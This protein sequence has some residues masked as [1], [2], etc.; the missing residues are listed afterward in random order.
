MAGLR[1]KER[2]IMEDHTIRLL[3]E[4][5]Q[6]CK[7]GIKSINQIREYVSDQGLK[8]IID[9]YQDEH[10]R[11]ESEAD[12][13]LVWH[14][15]DSR[16]PEKMAAA[17]AWFTTEMKMMM[18]DDD[19]QAAKLLTEGCNMG[20]QTICG[21]MNQYSGASKSSLALANDLVKTEEKFRD[22]MKLYL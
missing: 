19:K 2:K 1:Q 8:K 3:Q 4:C 9:K 7:M 5:S 13:L 20:I 11:L 22:E 21:F 6:G 10:R 16:P 12:H 17:M 15:Q 18:K 14:G